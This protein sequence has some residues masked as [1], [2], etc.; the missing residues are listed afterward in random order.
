MGSSPGVSDLFSRKKEF[1]C[2]FRSVEWKASMVRVYT[3]GKEVA[4]TI[5]AIKI[6]S[7]YYRRCGAREEFLCASTDRNLWQKYCEEPV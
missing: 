1:F 5:L 2:R 4:E 3:A 7:S 6:I